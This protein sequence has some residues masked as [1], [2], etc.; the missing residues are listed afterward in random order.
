MIFVL[1]GTVSMQVLAKSLLIDLRVPLDVDWL[2]SI[3]E[4]QCS[5]STR[6]IKE[7]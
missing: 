6:R 7:E 1:L 5:R 4:L 2:I 3:E